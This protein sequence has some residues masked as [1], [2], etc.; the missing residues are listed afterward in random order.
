MHEADRVKGERVAH[1]LLVYSFRAHRIVH[2]A[3]C[4]I[5]TAGRALSFSENNDIK[6]PC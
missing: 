4:M 2:R 6:I 1:H 5:D 3:P